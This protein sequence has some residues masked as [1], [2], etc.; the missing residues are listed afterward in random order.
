[1]IA[2]VITLLLKNFTLTFFLAGMV[3]AGIAILRSPAPRSQCLVR[4]KLLSHF[5]LFAVGFLYLYNCVLHTVFARMTAHFIGWADSP[6][7]L[8][9]G[10]RAWVL[11]WQAFW[12]FGAPMTSSS[13]RLRLLRCSC[14]GRAA[15]TSIRLFVTT[16]LRRGMR[17]PSS[18]P[19][20]GCRQPDFCC[21]T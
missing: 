15:G 3:S 4:E 6:F 17:E 19:I 8:E 18:T 1:M 16:T 2:A 5:V 13:W 12:D 21:S 10:S 7:Q 14:S 9:V 20:S 11:P